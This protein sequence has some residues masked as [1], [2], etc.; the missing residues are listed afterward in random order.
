MASST[1]FT[2]CIAA[3]NEIL[4]GMPSVDLSHGRTAQTGK[5]PE[6]ALKVGRELESR[7]MSNVDAFGLMEE[8]PAGKHA[9]RHGLC[10]CVAR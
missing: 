7:N 4:C 9:L 8:L 5:F 6:D 2:G 3:V 10:R 1:L